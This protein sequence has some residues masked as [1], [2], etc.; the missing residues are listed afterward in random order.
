MNEQKENFNT[1]PELIPNAER[2]TTLEAEI[3]KS[4]MVPNDMT[5]QIKNKAV[6]S[7]YHTYYLSPFATEEEKQKIVEILNNVVQSTIHHQ[8]TKNIAQKYLKQIYNS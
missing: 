1:N 4:E 6:K 7:L 5:Y 2:I 8:E 3:F